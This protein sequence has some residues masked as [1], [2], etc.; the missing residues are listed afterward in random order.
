MLEKVSLNI[1]DNDRL[2]GE[3]LSEVHALVCF[4]SLEECI[5]H[6]SV[7]ILTHLN[8]VLIARDVSCWHLI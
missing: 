3:Q 6:W 4:K 8:V 7:Q 5:E 1:N 2:P